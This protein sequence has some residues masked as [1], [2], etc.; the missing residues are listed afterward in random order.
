[1]AGDFIN[2]SSFLKSALGPGKKD[3][4]EG[5]DVVSLLPELSKRIETL[6]KFRSDLE[7]DY[8]TLD[9]PLDEYINS[10]DLII[11]R[12]DSLRANSRTIAIMTVDPEKTKAPEPPVLS[13]PKLSLSGT[14][15]VPEP[16]TEAAPMPVF[17]PAPSPVNNPS[18]SPEPAA[19]S[20]P[21]GDEILRCVEKILSG[22]LIPVKDDVKKDR[23]TGSC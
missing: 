15:P 3:I 22:P 23:K 18:A 13:F 4:K 14:M 17:S 8:N 6:R 2:M 20:D 7:Q 1:M 16:K 5:D 19:V 21:F 12:L 11:S 10:I 9:R